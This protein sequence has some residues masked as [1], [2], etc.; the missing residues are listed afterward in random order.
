MVHVVRTTEY[1]S[2]NLS[3]TYI[4]RYVHVYV[5]LSTSLATLVVHTTVHVYVLLSISLATV[6]TKKIATVVHVRTTEYI[7][8]N[9]RDE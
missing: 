9:R 6:G 8:G 4:P 3:S 2:G 1:I 7:S 5:L